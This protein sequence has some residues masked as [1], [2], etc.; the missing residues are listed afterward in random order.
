[1]STTT[2]IQITTNGPCD[3]FPYSLFLFHKIPLVSIGNISI[4]NNEKTHAYI[5][6]PPLFGR[7]TATPMGTRIA[8]SKMIKQQ[9][10]Q[11]SRR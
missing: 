6:Y 9:N 10:R 3:D 11:K 8:I 1:L 2:F 7:M 5:D 4:Y